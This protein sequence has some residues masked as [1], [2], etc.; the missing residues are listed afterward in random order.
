MQPGATQIAVFFHRFGP[1]HLARLEAAAAGGNLVGI[2]ISSETRDYAWD[3]V[4]PTGSLRVE[5]LFRGAD[6]RAVSRGMMGARVTEVLGRLRPHVVAVNGWSDNGALA[7]LAWCQRRGVPAIMMSESQA[8]DAPRSAPREAIKRLVVGCASAGLVGGAPHREYLCK[9]GM[10]PAHIFDGYDAID[11]EY[12]ARGAMA[13]RSQSEEVRASLRLPENYFLASC[14]FLPKKN[15][16]MLIQAFARY[17]GSAG[18]DAWHL[19]LLGDGD[20]APTLRADAERLKVSDLLHMPGFKQYPDLPAY[21][22]LARAFILPSLVEQWGLVVNEAM[23]SGLPVLVS[24]R[25]GCSRDLVREGENG[26][27]FDPQSPADLADLLGRLHRES[28]LTAMGRRSSALIEDWG[29]QRFAGGLWAAAEAAL[30]SPSPPAFSRKARATILPYL[31][32]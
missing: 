3:A 32:A 24:N 5:T 12:F 7:A 29:T 20:L 13:A 11:N 14:R 17:C 2:Q 6:S 28:D 22:G 31:A 30:K 15:L 16:P 26:H 18:A 9:L 10:S 21:Y 25:C 27:T 4:E 19:V 1:Y 8:I 23:A